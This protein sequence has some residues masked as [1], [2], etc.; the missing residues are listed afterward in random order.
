MKAKGRI[1]VII[2]AV[3]DAYAGNILQ[4]IHETASQLGDDVL[5]FT[6][7]SNRQP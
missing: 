7:S 4:R 1:A 6:N 5:I 3:R 2:P